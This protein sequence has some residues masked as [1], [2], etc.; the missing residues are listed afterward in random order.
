MGETVVRLFAYLTVC[1][2]TAC[3]LGRYRVEMVGKE[4]V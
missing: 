2:P 1:T 4:E 3:Y